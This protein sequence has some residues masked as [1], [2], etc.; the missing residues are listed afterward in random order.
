MGGDLINSV[1][2]WFGEVG[3]TAQQKT[4]DF[5]E[6]KS[7]KIQKIENPKQVAKVAAEI[8]SLK[9]LQKIAEEEKKKLC[10]SDKDTINELFK[11]D[12]D[13]F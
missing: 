12:P 10:E 4:C 11:D 7:E 9:E 3:E 2:S 13:F 1:V 6:E 8:K 5:L